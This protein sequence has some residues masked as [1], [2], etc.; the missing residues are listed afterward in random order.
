MRSPPAQ[1][2]DEEAAPEPASAGKHASGRAGKRK[3][4]SAA[5]GNGASKRGGMGAEKDATRSAW[6][7][8]KL[9]PLIRGELRSY[10]LQA[11]LRAVACL[12]T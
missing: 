12:A 2:V 1:E 10:Q 11:R 4:G 3:R 8:E 9:V 6:Q 7:Q 5:G